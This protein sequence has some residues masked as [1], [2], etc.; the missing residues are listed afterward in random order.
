MNP[1]YILAAVLLASCTVVYAVVAWTMVSAILHAI[2]ED[3]YLL[4]V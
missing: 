3:L 1:R 2:A 4:G